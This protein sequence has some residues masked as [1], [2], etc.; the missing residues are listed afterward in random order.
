MS[1]QR[2]SNSRRKPNTQ[3]KNLGMAGTV[4]A[5][6]R[7]IKGFDFFSNAASRTGF[8][9]P[10]L[11]EGTQY[12]LVRF[13][14]NYWELITLYRNHWISRRIVDT[15]AQDMVRAWPRLLCEWK[16]EDLDRI[17][18]LIKRTRVRQNMLTAIQWARL[19]GG[20]GALMII[21]GQED[22]LDQPLRL[23]DVELDSFKGIIPFDRWSGISPSGEVSSDISSPNDFNKPEYY[24]VNTPDAEMFKVHSSRVLRFLGPQVPTPEVQA[25]TWW[26]ISSLEPVY[27]EIRKRDNMSWNILALTFRANILGMKI[28]QLAQLLSGVGSNQ[29]AMQAF[30]ERM[31]AMNHLISNQSMIPLPEN[32][33]IESTQYTFSG[34]SEVYQQF[35][36][37]IS[38]AAQ[39]PVTRLWG[40]TITGLGQSNDADEAIYEER[41]ATDQEVDMRP[42]L[43]KLYPVMCMS[44]LGEVPD[45]LDLMF[46]SVR[47]LSE[48]E[49]AELASTTVNTL[50]VALNSGGIS[51]RTYAKELKASGELTGLFTN[52]T[53]EDIEKLPDEV[54]DESD[55]GA[56]LFGEREGE[57]NLT[58]GS[59]SQKVLREEGRQKEEKAEAADKDLRQGVKNCEWCGDCLEVRGALVCPNCA[60]SYNR[61]TNANDAEAEFEESDH[62]RDKSGKFAKSPGGGKASAN[63]TSELAENASKKYGTKNATNFIKKALADGELSH[64]EIAEVASELF[65]KNITKSYIGYVKK[66]EEK[67][68]AKKAAVQK[69]NQAI[70]NAPSTPSQVQQA[71]KASSGTTDLYVR[72]KD[73]NGKVV[74][75]RL[76][77]LPSQLSTSDLIKEYL[78]T[79]GYTMEFSPSN[80]NPNAP[81]PPGGYVD[82][83][84]HYADIDNLQKYA[85]KKA[86]QE[87]QKNSPVTTLHEP[88]TSGEVSVIKAYS[89]GAYHPLNKALRSGKKLSID[90]AV[91]AKQLDR[92]IRK[93]TLAEATTLRRGIASGGIESI[94]GGTV[95]IGD[96]VMDNGF[97][98][99]SKGSGFKGPIKLTINMPKGAHALDIQQYSH[100]Y[101]E[102]E[103]LLPRGS[104]FKVTNVVTLSGGVKL[105]V[106]YVEADAL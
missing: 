16:P 18:R 76:Q 54:E 45:D 27:E 56:G 82:L 26:G 31:T 78:K 74:R 51:K 32:G 25:Q 12:D 101:S 80:F 62:P 55:M 21:D 40:R 43:E 81:A 61:R 35:Q 104:M 49:K 93:A 28:P 89:D 60:E 72:C 90:Q 44:E 75:I 91:M 99:S 100:H 30:E 57:P 59:S 73:A 9:T 15:P 47:V 88:L 84:A 1:K 53:D 103:V 24:T 97:M 69:N 105:E 10:S 2:R 77:G 98:S 52:I 46:P 29:K 95:H 5:L 48:Q 85:E 34:L 66:Y 94:F 37:D 58:P 106:D 3:E 20:A 42:Q 83:K 8:G 33:G 36:L 65:D 86:K 19:F 39:I 102:S 38:G 87:A 17:E 23:D 79:K 92:A 50:T 7:I 64:G 63:P 71:V 96:V 70:K 13:S 41:I 14:Y 4:E 22:Q 11:T 67:K 6:Q 68:A